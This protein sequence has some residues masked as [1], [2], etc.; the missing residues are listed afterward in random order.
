MIKTTIDKQWH[1]GEVTIQGKKVINKSIFEIGLVVE[2]QA[3]LLAARKS[4]YLAAS[5]TTQSGTGEGTE[6]GNPSEYG[7]GI[8]EDGEGYSNAEMTIQAPDEE[9]QVYVGTPLDYGPHVEFGT[10]RQN[11]QPYLRPSLALAKGE[12]LT[13]VKNNG[14]LGFKEYLQ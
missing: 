6:P 9:N 5:I 2:G 12:A 11:A 10:V 4:G 1:G 13:I 14:R 8:A 7:S 3:K